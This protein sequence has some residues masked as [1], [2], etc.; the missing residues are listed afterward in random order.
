MTLWKVSEVERIWE[1]EVYVGRGGGGE[2]ML[3]RG[4]GGAVGM[5]PEGGGA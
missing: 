5:D 2:D 4:G 1:R 3:V